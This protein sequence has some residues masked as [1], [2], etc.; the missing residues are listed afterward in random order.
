MY[1]LAT[2]LP[3]FWTGDKMISEVQHISQWMRQLSNITILKVLRRS[4]ALSVSFSSPSVQFVLTYQ[5]FSSFSL[6]WSALVP[7]SVKKELLQRIRAFLAQHAT[8]WTR[9]FPPR[10]FFTRRRS[11]IKIQTDVC[12]H[13]E[14]CWS[15]I[16]IFYCVFFIL[17]LVCYAA[18][19]ER[20]KK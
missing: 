10:H 5:R 6:S 11:T 7:D 18:V 12:S 4:N 13:C 8:L 2:R 19:L 20:G 16:F 9:R 3:F 14:Q 1:L 15:V 17:I